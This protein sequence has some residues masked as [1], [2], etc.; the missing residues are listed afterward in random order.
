MRI[1]IAYHNLVKPSSRPSSIVRNLLHGFIKIANLMNKDGLDL[2]FLSLYK[3]TDI[4]KVRDNIRIVGL[5]VTRPITLTLE[6]Q[7]FLKRVGEFDLVPTHLL[8]Y[9]LRF[10]SR[11][12]TIYT[13]HGVMWKEIRYYRVVCPKTWLAL[14]LL[15][16]KAY[17]PLLTKLVLISPY[18]LEELEEYEAKFSPH[19][20]ALIENPISDLYFDLAKNEDEKP[21]LLIN[22]N[23]L[24]GK[25]DT[26]RNSLRESDGEVKV[27]AK[28]TSKCT[29]RC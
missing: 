27:I 20:I 1:L 19:R 25:W 5:L 10:S 13:L 3:N 23:T 29:K 12:P 4:V 2:T 16:L 11:I 15:H 18:L 7:S 26:K 17:L 14:M 21:L 28:N 8:H 6:L 9:V 24:E 22:D